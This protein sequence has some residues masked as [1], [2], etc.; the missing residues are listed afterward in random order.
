[1]LNCWGCS[2]HHK[3]VERAELCDQAAL[4]QTFTQFVLAAEMA[5]E[6]LC[7]GHWTE[8]VL[9]LMAIVLNVTVAGLDITWRNALKIASFY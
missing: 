3:I 2:C 5:Y 6:K 9:Q 1:M 8:F 4:T 7:C